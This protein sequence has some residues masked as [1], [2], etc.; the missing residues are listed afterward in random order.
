MIFS[1]YWKEFSAIFFL[2]NSLTSLLQVK[3]LWS[4]LGASLLIE[5]FPTVQR[6][7][8]EVTWFG[9]SQCDKPNKKIKQTNYLPSLIHHWSNILSEAHTWMCSCIQE[10]RDDTCPFAFQSP[11]IFQIN[12]THSFIHPSNILC[13]CKPPSPSFDFKQ[14]GLKMVGQLYKCTWM[15]N[16]SCKISSSFE[17]WAMDIWVAK[18]SFAGAKAVVS[19]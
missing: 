4:Q 17:Y 6:V 9:R 13:L 14:N 18:Y 7:W 2:H 11:C 19:F 10:I 12:F 1:F 16:L 8:Q 3:T 15:P 5:G